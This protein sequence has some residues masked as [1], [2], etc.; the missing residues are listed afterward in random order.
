LAVQNKL[1][2]AFATVYAREIAKL[3]NRPGTYHLE[4]S[5]GYYADITIED[6][7]EHVIIRPASARDAI[8]IRREAEFQEK[9]R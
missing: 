9:R 5:T 2:E 1:P 3:G 8:A 6:R 4:M 7:G